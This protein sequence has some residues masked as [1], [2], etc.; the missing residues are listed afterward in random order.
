MII[1]GVADQVPECIRRLVYWNAFVPNNGECINDM[2][3]P[4]FVAL[5]DQISAQRGDSSVVLPFPIW[6]EALS[7]PRRQRRPTT[8]SIHIRS[9]PSPTRFR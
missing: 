8:F 7:T 4:P 2:V 9:R 5:F 6:R 3:S 1:T